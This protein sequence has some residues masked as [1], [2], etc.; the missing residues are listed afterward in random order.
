MNT[1]TQL[2]V[3]RSRASRM[4][5]K[6]VSY[7]CETKVC[8]RRNKAVQSCLLCTLLKPSSIFFPI[9]TS[10]LKG[11]QTK[12]FIPL[13]I[14][15]N[16][17]VHVVPIIIIN[18]SASEVVLRASY[19]VFVS[20]TPV[21]S[22]CRWTW[23]TLIYCNNSKREVEFSMIEFDNFKWKESVLARFNSTKH[24]YINK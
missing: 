14:N 5:Q 11:Y 22:S 17:A 24:D 10:P 1:F 8:E 13:I 19:L 20:L 7:I 23:F 21:T 16:W 4:L 2:L 9:V 3:G 12:V 15:N 6:S 18:G